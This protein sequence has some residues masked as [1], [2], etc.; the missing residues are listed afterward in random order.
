MPISKS[1]QKW[2]MV[3]LSNDAKFVCA[4]KNPP[5][6]HNTST[7]SRNIVHVIIIARKNINTGSHWKLRYSTSIAV[8]HH[9]PF[10]SRTTVC[11]SWRPSKNW[12]HA[13]SAVNRCGDFIERLRCCPLRNFLKA[14][15]SLPESLPKKIR[16]VISACWVLLISRRFWALGAQKKHSPKSKIN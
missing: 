3:R 8:H 1:A 7:H 15:S 5:T 2:G 12:S 4:S 10:R 16:I 14:P 13:R 9:S 11:D 6:N